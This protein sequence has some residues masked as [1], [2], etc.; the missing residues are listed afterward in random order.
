LRIVFLAREYQ[1]G[2]QKRATFWL[3]LAL[4]VV[5]G[6]LAAMFDI[7]RSQAAAA[8]IGFML[9]ATL[10]IAGIPAYFAI[11]NLILLNQIKRNPAKNPYLRTLAVF[12]DAWEIARDIDTHLAESDGVF[13][14]RYG[15]P[16]I[17]EVNLSAAWLV[18]IMP[19]T[20]F[21]APVPEMDW[22]FKRLT[23]RPQA[24]HADQFDVD[25]IVHH[26]RGVEP[27]PFPH[28]EAADAVMEELLN[29]RPEL[30]IG[31]LGEWMDLVRRGPD[32]VNEA[33]ATRRNK[34]DQYTP[35]QQF[36]WREDQL[37]AFDGHVR[38][39]D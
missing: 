2:C 15:G 32:V 18:R 16:G 36:E 39:A 30:L 22:V 23:L 35:N 19:R 37:D 11:V 38:R 7:M 3:V 21:A 31:H 9:L 8:E 10:F 27:F 12:G 28:E 5:L 34:Y 4:L 24:G 26:R 14:V 17:N 6:C 1:R 13:T 25:M 29:H 33:L 20:V